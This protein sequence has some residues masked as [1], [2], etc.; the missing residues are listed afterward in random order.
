MKKI[1]VGG[2]LEIELNDFGTVF[3]DK[4]TALNSGRNAF[5]YILLLNGFTRIHIPYFTCEVLLQPLLKHNI[6]YYFYPIDEDF[7]PVCLNYQEGDAILYTNY[8]G[9]NQIG[10]ETI[11]NRYQNVI[12]DNAQA[13]FDLP[14]KNTHTFY[15]PRKFFG[16]PDGGFAYTRL[17]K[18]VDDYEIDKSYNRMSHLFLRIEN[19]AEMGYSQFK[20]NNKKLDNEPIKLM[21]RIT[22][23]LLKNIDYMKGANIRLSNFNF[24]HFHLNSIN[25]LTKIID[26][27]N[28][29]GPLVYPLWVENAQCLRDKLHQNKIFTATYW[30][31]VLHW[32][33]SNSIES[34]LTRNI[35]CLPIDHRMGFT[36][37][38]RI[39]SLIDLA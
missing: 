2:Y 24:L 19:G 18:K 16:V 15:S 10:V 30:P 35:I 31:N 33:S 29:A 7:L 4:A 23:S 32:V 34:D 27:T 22:Q 8:F 25:K 14:V 11:I 12:I 20:E 37:L 17:C 39:I 9:I 28:L 1:A 21:S 6:K 38:E 3:H 5:E 13:F 26:S 36:Q